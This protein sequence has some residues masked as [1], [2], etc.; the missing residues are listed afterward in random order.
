M[1]RP[2]S[3]I[4]PATLFVYAAGPA[5]IELAAA[6]TAGMVRHHPFVDGNKRTAFVVGALFLE[7]HGLVLRASEED[8]AN[9]VQMLAGKGI[10]EQDYADFVRR[11]AQ[12]A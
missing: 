5:L 9:A 6:Y 7:L 2:G 8:A 4:T 11:F 3:A 12:T 10:K 1:A